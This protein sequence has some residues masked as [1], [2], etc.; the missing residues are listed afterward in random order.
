MIFWNLH[1]IH[2]HK[3]FIHGNINHSNVMYDTNMKLKLIDFNVANLE[4]TYRNY[5]IGRSIY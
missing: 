1:E 2:S 3:K 5:D 4:G